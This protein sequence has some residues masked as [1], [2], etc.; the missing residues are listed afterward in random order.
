MEVDLTRVRYILEY[1]EDFL[2]D[3]RL[4]HDPGSSRKVISILH[5]VTEVMW[6]QE[7][8]KHFENYT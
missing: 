5:Q 6:K 1:L 4:A 7:K 8:A 3:D 2:R